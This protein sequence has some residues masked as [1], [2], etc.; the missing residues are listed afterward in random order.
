M[1]TVS[2]IIPTHNHGNLISQTLDSVFAQTFQDYEVIVVND[3]STDDTEQVLAPLARQG[4]ISYLAQG[5]RG[6]AAARNHGLTRAKGQFIAFLDDD[7]L[8]PSDKLQWQVEI[9]KEQPDTVLVYGLCNEF[10]LREGQ[11]PAPDA[12]NGDVA[13]RFLEFNYIV[14]PGSTLIRADA[15]RRIEGFDTRIWGADDWD[16]YLRLARIGKFAYRDRLAL[17]YRCHLNN[18]SQNFLRMYINC[19][20]VQR[21]HDLR[22]MDRAN[23]RPLNRTMRTHY[24]HESLRKASESFDT[25]EFLSGFGWW[26]QAVRI[27]AAAIVSPRALGAL[28]DGLFPRPAALWLRWLGRVIR[29]RV[30]WIRRAVV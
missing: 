10:G 2:V 25:C 29:W 3:G 21:R 9:L 5:N 17:W 15:L 8:W 28:V 1:C 27:D 16:L 19:C 20:M 26:A 23:Y 30:P 22:Q 6:Q 4:R 11:T 18:A 12:P 13:D 14:S 24:C 7:D